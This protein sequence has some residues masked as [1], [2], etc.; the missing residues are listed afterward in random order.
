MIPQWLGDDSVTTRWPK[1]PGGGTGPWRGDVQL[2]EGGESSKSLRP[3]LRLNSLEKLGTGWNRLETGDFGWMSLIVSP[4]SIWKNQSNGDWLQCWNMMLDILEH[5][6]MFRCHFAVAK[7]PVPWFC[8]V[9]VV[10]G[11]KAKV[12][13]SVHHLQHCAC[14]S[15]DFRHLYHLWLDYK[16]QLPKLPKLPCFLYPQVAIHWS[17]SQ[18]FRT[19][20][21]SFHRLRPC[22]SARSMQVE[23]RVM[24]SRN[25]DRKAY[26]TR[27]R[28][29][30]VLV[31]SK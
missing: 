4:C 23:Q 8:S 5:E 7:G 9:S 25:K 11:S 19:Q 22:E 12:H 17:N 21:Q 18:G 3:R 29:E 27:C 30:L 16:K 28:K 26:R 10:Q 15:H 2:G 1:S 20:S 6:W 14:V 13:R 24:R 31:M